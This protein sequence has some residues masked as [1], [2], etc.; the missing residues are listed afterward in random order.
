[1]RCNPSHLPVARLCLN[2][3]LLIATV[4]IAGCG[5]GVESKTKDLYSQVHRLTP[6]LELGFSIALDSGNN[7]YAYTL[8]SGGGITRFVKQSSGQYTA[9]R[10]VDGGFRM[11]VSP[12]SGR[13]FVHD[14]DKIKVYDNAGSLLA[15]KPLTPTSDLTVNT[16]GD[17]FAQSGDIIRL[18]EDGN[19]RNRFTTG[20]S[21]RYAEIAADM[22]NN[23]V[24]LGREDIPGASRPPLIMRVFSPEGTLLRE[25]PL[26]ERG[27]PGGLDFDSMTV[28]RTGKVYLTYGNGSFNWSVLVFH[29]QTGKWLGTQSGLEDAAGDIAVDASGTLYIMGG[30]QISIY[31]P[32]S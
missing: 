7:I 17:L 27:F 5:G 6:G 14:T 23:V 4:T 29:Y 2:F 16:R 9:S 10:A 25:T 32:D 13:I 20:H 12:V 1:M 18:D 22:D 26:E 3:F 15:E 21:Y 30:F 31:K 28:G 8:S 11:A 24:V 19:E